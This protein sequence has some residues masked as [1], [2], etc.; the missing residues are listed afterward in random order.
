[1]ILPSTPILTAVLAANARIWPFVSPVATT[2]DTPPTE[3]VVA[4][5]VWTA[6]VLSQLLAAPDAAPAVK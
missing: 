5:P 2:V 6:T 3:A 4:V 1:M